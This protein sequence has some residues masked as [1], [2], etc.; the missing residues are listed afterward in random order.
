MSNFERNKNY[1]YFLL[2]LAM[3][4]A[5]F[6]CTPKS[7]EKSNSKVS[8]INISDGDLQVNPV[9]N[10]NFP[11]PT[12]IKAHDGKYY[13]YATNTASKGKVIHIQVARS[14]N[15][16]DWE[17]VGDALP[18]KPSWA[19]KDFWAPH[20]LYY[21]TVQ[22]YYLYYSGE[23]IDGSRGFEEID[24]MAFDDPLSGKKFLY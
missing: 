19:D 1:F 10:S 18:V 22:T 9:I 17:M 8:E 11:D 20:V 24:P 13:V 6:Y 2:T 5:L 12:I 21:S 4:Q 15:L 14:K 16:D 23:S 7:R 3:S